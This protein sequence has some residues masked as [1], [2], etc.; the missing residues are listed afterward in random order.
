MRKIFLNTMQK[1]RLKI[2]YLLQEILKNKNV[3][4]TYDVN[5]HDC[6]KS[7]T[8]QFRSLSKVQVKIYYKLRD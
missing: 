1:I 5:G 3:S 7:K 8:S 6:F 2:P 4:L